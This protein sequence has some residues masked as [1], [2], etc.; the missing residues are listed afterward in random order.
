MNRRHYQSGKKNKNGQGYKV[1]QLITKFKKI[2]YDD[3]EPMKHY[4]GYNGNVPPWIMLKG[5]T[6][7]NLAN[8][9]K[10]MICQIKLE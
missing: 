10:F 4:R 8:F 1:D 5:T 2:I 9:Y 7:G 6:F 3:I